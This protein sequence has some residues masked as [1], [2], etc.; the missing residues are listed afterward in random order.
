MQQ[1]CGHRVTENSEEKLNSQF[2]TYRFP[3]ESAAESEGR[4][5]NENPFPSVLSAALW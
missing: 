3:P 2:M 4:K 1:P 5:D